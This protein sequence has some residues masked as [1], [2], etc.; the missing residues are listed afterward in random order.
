MKKAAAFVAGGVVVAL[1]V[2][3]TAPRY[4]SSALDAS[5]MEL[6]M[7]GATCTATEP[8]LLG[9]SKGKKVAWRIK[10]S[11]TSAQYV[12][13]QNFK[14]KHLNDNNYDTPD[15]SAVDPYPPT[16]TAA[17]A[18]GDTVTVETTINKRPKWVIL[19]DTYKYDVY[20]GLD[21]TS[22]ARVLDPD[23]EIWP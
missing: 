14:R 4:L 17:I 12:Q 22:L 20:I 3:A 9:N 6:R 18:P 19:T 21:L 11:C 7:S 16:T 1:V 23:I 5:D 15:N 8:S 13:F 2:T 10:N